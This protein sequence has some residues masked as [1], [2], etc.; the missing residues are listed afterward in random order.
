MT[1]KEK[2]KLIA[3]LVD[4]I[5]GERP[6]EQKLEKAFAIIAKSLK[7]S[8]IWLNLWTDDKTS[9][10]A[11]FGL[12]DE[13]KRIESILHRNCQCKEF[14][15][16][17]SSKF[18]VYKIEECPHVDGRIFGNI[19]CHLS[20][21]LRSG[22]SLIGTLNFGMEQEE[23]LD[24]KQLD[25]ICKILSTAFANKVYWDWIQEQKELLLRQKRDMEVFV[26]AVSHDMKTPIIAVKG[27]INLINKK[28]KD[29]MPKELNKYIYQIGKGIERIDE[30][31]RDLLN[32]SRVDKVLTHK[33]KIKI[34]E[35]IL[36]SLK[37]IRSHIRHR[38]PKIKFVGEKTVVTGNWLA[39]FHIFTN[40]IAN[41]IKYT[42]D[43]RRPTVEI[44]I[45]KDNN[46]W[47]FSIKDNGIG[48]TE[49]EK[50]KVFEPFTKV[51]TLPRE[52]SGVGLSIVKR[53]VE[54]MGG[55]LWL[56]SVKGVGTTFYI[57]LPEEKEVNAEGET[58][59]RTGLTPLDPE[60]SVSANSTTSAS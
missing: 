45:K 13:A 3:I 50:Q 46:G 33:E 31:A 36:A 5:Y 41:A 53:L 10:F 44:T 52:G 12:K 9:H 51:K 59:T 21:P 26:S 6:L 58:R 54:G 35:V 8:A 49:K 11:S 32:L 17:K 47:I 4:V 25:Q 39:F 28:Y 22:K 7:L 43:D 20:V 14:L 29:K 2:L 23:S 30:L 40:I 24:E 57:Y 15:T 18:N 42:P 60:P 34:D 56:E 38:K 37:S 55:K 27:F 1:E 16:E 48:L 19:S